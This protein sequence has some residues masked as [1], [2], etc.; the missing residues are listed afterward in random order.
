MIRY[1]ASD[2]DGTLLLGN[3]QTLDPEIFQLILQLKEQGIHFI[4]A[5]GRQYYNLY[6]LF[7]P[8]QNDISYIAENGSLCIH[9]GDVISRGTIDRE[10][11][12]RIIDVSRKL[13]SCE[14]MLSCESRIYTETKNP[15]FLHYLRDILQYDLENVSNL[16]DI[17]EPFLKLAMCDFSGTTQIEPFFKDHFSSEISVVTSGNIWVDFIA[18]GAHKG[19]GLVNV[20]KYLGLSPEDGIA[21]G[22]QYNDIEMLETAGTSYAMEN[23]A[24][25]VETHADFQTDSVPKILRKLLENKENF[26]KRR[27]T[28]ANKSKMKC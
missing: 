26:Q 23:C 5:S 28:K 16:H 15:K 1:I 4:A 3:S 2:L 17:H 13:P 6:N 9:Q 27:Q 7:G 20:A 11:G 14:C 8:V 25:G 12:L 18:P 21:F 24:P 19:S 10:L 22:D